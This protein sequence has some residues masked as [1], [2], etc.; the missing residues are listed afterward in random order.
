MLGIV[1]DEQYREKR[2]QL[3]PGDR[4]CFYT[5]GLVEARNGMGEGYGTERLEAAFAA[6]GALAAGPLA[7]RLLADQRAFR[8][9]V[10]LGDD[11]T[12]VVIELCADET[13]GI[14]TIVM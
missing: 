12:L 3:E 14:D 1:P 10:P 6:H 13:D 8:G 4:L 7:E 2:V 9:D 5:D 11:V